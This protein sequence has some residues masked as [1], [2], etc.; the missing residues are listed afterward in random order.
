MSLIFNSKIHDFVIVKGEVQNVHDCDM[1]AVLLFCLVAQSL[2]GLAECVTD[3]Y[4]FL[5][6]LSWTVLEM[7]IQLPH[8]LLELH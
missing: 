7:R 3:L 2:A 5:F 4:P 6:E 8:L 1:C